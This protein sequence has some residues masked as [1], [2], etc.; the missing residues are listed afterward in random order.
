MVKRIAVVGDR[1]V[2]KTAVALELAKALNITLLEAKE[3]FLELHYMIQGKRIK[4]R[5][6]VGFYPE[7]DK[8][9]CLRCNICAAVCPDRAM[10]RDWEGYP[11]AL[12]ELCSACTS[13][14]RACPEGALKPS[15]NVVAEVWEIRGRPR[16]VQAT[17]RS[18]KAVVKE[19]NEEWVMDTDRPELGLFSDVVLIL[20]D[21]EESKRYAIKLKKFYEDNDLPALLLGNKGYGSPSVPRSV[22]PDV[23]VVLA[24]LENF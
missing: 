20:Y 21:D 14:F 9:R 24:L 4:L 3:S 7:V 6:F 1:G 10:I 18:L 17:G 15:E 13:C 8:E 5:D 19:I 22:P 2:G 16:V 12:P 11:Y 23:R